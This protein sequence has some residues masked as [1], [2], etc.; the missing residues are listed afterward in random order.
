MLTPQRQGPRR[1]PYIRAPEVQDLMP[2]EPRRRH[3][4]P[5]VP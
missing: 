5:G 4:L 2:T 3:W 1:S